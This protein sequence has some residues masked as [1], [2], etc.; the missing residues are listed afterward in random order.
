MPGWVSPHLC[1]VPS[2]LDTLYLPLFNSSGTNLLGKGWE[3]TCTWPGTVTDAVHVEVPGSHSS[4]WKVAGTSALPT[5]PVFVQ[6]ASLSPIRALRE[7]FSIH[8]G[9]PGAHQHQILNLIISI[10]STI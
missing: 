5:S 9:N 2:H 3:S 7:A 4:S 1:P 6:V 8:L 10:N